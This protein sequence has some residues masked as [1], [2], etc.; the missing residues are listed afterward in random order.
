MLKNVPLE[1]LLKWNQ[2]SNFLWKWKK[3]VLWVSAVENDA[4]LSGDWRFM[5][6]W[7][8][9]LISLIPCL[10]IAALI[11][12]CTVFTFSSFPERWLIFYQVYKI[13]WWFAW[14][15]SIKTKAMPG[16]RLSTVKF[17][18]N[19]QSRSQL[20]PLCPVT[21]TGPPTWAFSKLL[22]T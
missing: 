14:F 4:N 11:H 3:N 20:T 22:K 5:A 8:L 6:G 17:N 1:R 19:Q 21:L 9:A 18:Y 13:E 7:K 2:C 12:P 10:F 15:N 16:I